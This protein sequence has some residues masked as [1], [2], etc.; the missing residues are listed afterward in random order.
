[1]PERVKA[2][3]AGFGCNPP[4]PDYLRPL[5]ADITER[6]P[7]RSL[8]TGS[9]NA[10]GTGSSNPS[11]SSAES[12][13]LRSLSRDLGL[14]TTSDECRRDEKRRADHDR[15]QR[16]RRHKFEVRDKVAEVDQSSLAQPF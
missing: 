13:N 9:L 11:P 3:I 5:S 7:K 14:A 6:G 16:L 10:R 1:M 2:I 15:V 4:S 12:A 8:G